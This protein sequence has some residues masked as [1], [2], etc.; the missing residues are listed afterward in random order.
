MSFPKYL[1]LYDGDCILCNSTVRLLLNIDRKAK[2]RFCALQSE[3]GQRLTP[4]FKK[5]A[6]SM[7]TIVFVNDGKVLYFSSA[8]LGIF[9][10]LG[11]PYN[12]LCFFYIVPVCIRDFIYKLIARK[13]YQLF[14]KT[15]SCK[16]L[17]PK[18]KNRF[19]VENQLPQ[20]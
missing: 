2:L 17:H 20:D 8:V 16:M 18:Y 4:D 14:G 9:S 19:L 15:K 12:M 10:V 1:V 6:S 7:E 11:F 5:E 3:L 13:R